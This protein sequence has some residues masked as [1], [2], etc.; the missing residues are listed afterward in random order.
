MVTID[1]PTL[2]S[3]QHEVNNI[4]D[5]RF[6]GRTAEDWPNLVA[7]IDPIPLNEVAL[8]FLSFDEFT[9]DP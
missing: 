2:P 8:E 3:S 9:F 1:D 4:K 5:Y 7:D 6:S